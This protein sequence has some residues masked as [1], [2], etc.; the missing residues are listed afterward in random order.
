MWTPEAFSMNRERFELH[1]LVRKFFDR[2]VAEGVTEGLVGDDRFSVDGTLIRSLAGHKSIQ[3]IKQDENDD[4]D[5]NDLN[6]W[7]QF[8]GKKRSNATHRYAMGHSRSQSSACEQRR[9]SAPASFDAS[10]DRFAHGVVRWFA[11]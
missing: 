3:P 8:K 7:G 10:V 1:D 9:R 5:D 2:L 4:E 11:C 6:S